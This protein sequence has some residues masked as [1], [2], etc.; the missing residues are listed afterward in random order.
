MISVY[1]KRIKNILE[2]EKQSII[3]SLSDSALARLSKKRDE[4]LYLA[5]LCALSLLKK[6]EREDLDYKKNGRPFFRTLDKDISISHSK[7]QV[8]VAISDK[9]ATS[10]GI[11]IEDLDSVKLSPR[12]L[13]ENEQK[14][15]IDEQIFIE[16][17]T[18][19]EALFKF[20]KN[21][22]ISFIQLDSTRPEFFGASFTTFEEGNSIITVCVPE[23]EKIEIIQK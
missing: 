15:A 1:I 16:I 19:K 10:V 13:T 8:A 5:S 18:K 17:W 23:E 3:A 4:E 20:L 22:S 7:T 14:I 9:Q 11:D 2:D 6:E 12:F 21:D